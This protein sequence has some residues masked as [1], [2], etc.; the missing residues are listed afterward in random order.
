[1]GCEK[2]P[3]YFRN[4]VSDKSEVVFGSAKVVTRIVKPDKLKSTQVVFKGELNDELTSEWLHSRD[5]SK[6][7]M[8]QR[9]IYN[10]YGRFEIRKRKSK[11]GKE[12]IIKVFVTF[13]AVIMT[14]LIFKE[15]IANPPIVNND[16]SSD[17]NDC[18][19]IVSNSNEVSESSL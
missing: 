10:R 19:E 18:K 13:I 17:D 11:R 15:L 4:N 3:L 6:E 8:E 1:M 5:M 16:E 14:P 7:I 2:N 9:N 12:N